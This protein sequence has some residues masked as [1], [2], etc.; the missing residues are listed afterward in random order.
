MTR[1]CP[2]CMDNR[3]ALFS[4]EKDFRIVTCRGCGLTYLQNPPPD[5]ALYEEYYQDLQRQPSEELA[6]II[7]LRLVLLQQRIPQ[8]SL[9]D[10]G[11]GQGF[12]LA[13]AQSAGYRVQG[14][15]VSTS[16]IAFATDTLRMEAAT[17]SLDE[18]LSRQTRFDVI[19]LW[20]VLEHFLNPV[21]ELGKIKQLLAPGGRCFIEVPNLHSAKFILSGKK[22]VGG[23]HPRYHR[24]FFTRTTLEETMRKSGFKK[25]ERISLSYSIP[26]QTRAYTAAKQLANFFAAD[27]FLDYEIRP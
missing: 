20:H 5:G 17:T 11:C 1:L 18:L 10:V 13:K 25:I 16:A 12:F 15:D 3:N 7:A 24:T 19:T 9:L 4:I 6:S 26:G 14:I 23:N 21:K 8:G 2:N 27:A 22:W